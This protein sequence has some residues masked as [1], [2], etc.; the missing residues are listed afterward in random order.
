MF[1]AFAQRVRDR[2]ETTRRRAEMGVSLGG[3]IRVSW[4]IFLIVF[5]LSSAAAAQTIR[6]GSVAGNIV[7]ESGAVLPGVTVN[8][9]GPNLQVPVVSAVSGERGEYQVLDLP[10]GTFRVSYELPGFATMVREGIVLNAGFQAR[11]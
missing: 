7:D 9:S 4:T 10:P 3:R 11:V 1:R 8:V 2:R 6:T 5:G